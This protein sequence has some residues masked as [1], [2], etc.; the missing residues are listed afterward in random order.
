YGNSLHDL[1]STTPDMLLQWIERT[2]L[3]K[4]GKLIVPAFSVER[5]Q[6][7]LYTLNQLEVENRLPDVD[8][9]LDSPL[10]IEATDLVKKYPQYFNKTIQKVLETDSDPFMFKGLKYLKTVEQS[11]LL[12]FRSEPCVFF[13]A[14]GLA[15]EGGVN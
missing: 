6:E 10:S 1:V 9:F 13:S 3:Q 11:K 8:Y 4:H 14:S 15:V 12:N 2:C 5:T 7:I